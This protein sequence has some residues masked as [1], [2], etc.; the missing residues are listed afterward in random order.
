MALA[1]TKRH[2]KGQ[3]QHTSSGGDDVKF[4]NGKG[5]NRSVNP[6]RA[7]TF[8][9]AVQ[10]ATLTEDLFPGAGFDRARSNAALNGARD[11]WRRDEKT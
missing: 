7:V 2:I 6:N 5:P 4:F 1:V 9:A 8:G 10:A 11:D 3:N